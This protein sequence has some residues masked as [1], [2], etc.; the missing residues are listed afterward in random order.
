MKKSIRKN[1]I[2][3]IILQL[4]YY[5]IYTNIPMPFSFYFVSKCAITPV[6]MFVQ[7]RPSDFNCFHMIN[8]IT[9]SLSL[10]IL[11]TLC[12]LM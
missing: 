1:I 9:F 2:L 12:P 4:Q 7:S 11:L 6:L 10:K 5:I 8:V 3:R